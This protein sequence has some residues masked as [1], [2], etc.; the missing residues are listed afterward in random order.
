MRVKTMKDDT[1]KKPT[2]KSLLKSMKLLRELLDEQ[3]VALL[4]LKFDV[5]ATRRERDYWIKKAGG[6]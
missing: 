1:K 2:M 5:E 6:K 4:Y 3:R